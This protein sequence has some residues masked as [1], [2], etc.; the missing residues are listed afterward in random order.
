MSPWQLYR[1]VLLNHVW[2]S[3]Y[4]LRRR[5][6]ARSTRRFKWRE[7]DLLLA[8]GEIEVHGI[9]CSSEISIRHTLFVDGRSSLVRSDW[10]GPRLFRTA[11]TCRSAPISP[12]TPVSIAPE[13]SLFGSAGNQSENKPSRVT[14]NALEIRIRFFNEGLRRAHS[15]PPR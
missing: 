5:D 3:C 12:N 6:H 14:S 15:I 2:T 13:R 11:A 9:S 7:Q 10:G 8:A 4:W 1:R